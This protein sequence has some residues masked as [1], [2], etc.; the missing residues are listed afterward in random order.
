MN[1][2][3]TQIRRAI[4]AVR[5]HDPFNRSW[6]KKITNLNKRPDMQFQEIVIDL[7]GK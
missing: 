1:R 3:A 5:I 7:L 6:G 4:I 2:I